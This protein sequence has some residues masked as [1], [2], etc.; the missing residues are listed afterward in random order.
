M[1]RHAAGAQGAAGPLSTH[2]T[3]P[4]EMAAGE[5]GQEHRLNIL[6]AMTS[7]SSLRSLDVAALRRT[8]R[9]LN[10]APAAPWLHT[11]VSR[12]MVERLAVIRMQPAV[13]ADWG[14]FLG[15]SH[16]GLRSAYPQARIVAVEQDAARRAATARARSGPWW[17]F[18][19]RRDSVQLDT[20]LSAGQVQMLWSNM[21]LHFAADPLAEMSAWHRTLAVDGFLMFSTLGPGT[22]TGLQALYADAGWGQPFAPFVDMH[23]LGDMLV[24]AGF[25]EPVMDQE[26]LTLTWATPEQALAELRGLGANLALGRAGGLRTP[27]WRARLL[28]ALGTKADAQ[29]RVALAFELVY[30]HAF[31]PAPRPRVAAETA[32][33]LEDLRTMA[34]QPRPGR[35]GRP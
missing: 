25:A 5:V 29:G 18:G 30:G 14:A 13:V 22:L 24:E 19:R 23:D 17:A 33:A 11:E 28:R 16:A 34:R 32:V 2:L 3:L 7:R 20:E 6:P 21:G 26:T 8:L 27:R 10:A 9:R 31:R 1:A 12:R 15:A 4:L 35:P